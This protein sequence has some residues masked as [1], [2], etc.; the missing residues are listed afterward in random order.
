MEAG[1]AIKRKTMNKCGRLKGH[2]KNSE[3]T[4]LTRTGKFC[5][6]KGGSRFDFGENIQLLKTFGA[7]S[8]ITKSKL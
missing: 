5:G 3:N 1:D 2:L 8:Y 7:K 4:S 6:N